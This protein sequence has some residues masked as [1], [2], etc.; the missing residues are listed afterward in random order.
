MAM[1]STGESVAEACA[2]A[3]LTACAHVIFLANPMMEEVGVDEV[4]QL[5]MTMIDLVLVKSQEQGAK[6]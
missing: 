6:P 4:V 5:A 2:D 3:L 1:P